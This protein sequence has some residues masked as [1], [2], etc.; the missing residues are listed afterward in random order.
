MA[1]PTRH[2]SKWRIRWIDHTGKRRSEVHERFEDAEIALH[3]HKLEAAEIRR[4]SRLPIARGKT[5]A[6]LADYWLD[7]RTTRKRSAKDDRSIIERHL[8]PAFGHLCLSN[9]GVAHVDAFVA[10]RPHLSPKTVHNHLTL[11]ISMLNLAVDLGWLLKAPPIKKP[12]VRLV[13]ED[14]RYL[15]T[16]AELRAFLTA[17]RAEDEII[18]NLYVTAVYTGLRAGELAG[19]RWDDIDIERRLISVQRSYEGPTKSGR[20]RH[21][22][23]LDPLLPVLRAWRLRHPGRLVFTN[24]DGRMLGPS[25][26]AFQEV[27]HRCLDG[28]GF[29]SPVIQG[30]RRWHIT[31]HGLRH[32]FASHWVMGGG[33]I[34]RLQKILGHSTLDMTMRYAHL[35]PDAFSSDF[36]RLTDQVPQ[37]IADVAWLPVGSRPVS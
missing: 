6:K 23:I 27:L 14:F 2:R 22:P 29:E 10:E 36:G 20:S 30:R 33:D 37:R 16:E 24:R 17:A 3:R 15:R 11:L 26:R 21:V 8:R 31:F 34:F 25:A 28:A 9:L 7:A 4:G 18:Y 19:L 12:R 1:R 5:F 35:A 32:T 13:G